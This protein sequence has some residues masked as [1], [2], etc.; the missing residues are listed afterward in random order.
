MKTSLRRVDDAF[1]MEARNQSGHIVISDDSATIG[2]HGLGIRPMEMLI[3]ALGACSSIDVIH[4]LHKMRQPLKDIEV[5]I[6]AERDTDNVPALF[7]NV[8]ITYMIKGNLDIKKVEKVIS[9][10]VDKYCSVARILEK[11]STIT[12]AYTIVPT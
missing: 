2:G 5:D 3:S 10:F 12:W 11:T 8:D 1:Q 9:L 6:D 4:F 7:T